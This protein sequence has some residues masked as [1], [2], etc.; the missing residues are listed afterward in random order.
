[1]KAIMKTKRQPGVEF[2][3]V[4]SPRVGPHDVLIRVHVAGICGTDFHIYMWDEWSAGRVGPPIVL[5]H[6][7]IGDVVDVGAEVTTVEVGDCV[8]AEGH[9]SCGQCFQ[10][11]TG[12]QHICERV[13][14]IGIDRDGCFAE[15]LSVPERNVWKMDR[16]IPSDVAAITDPIGNA[17]HTV[18]SG[19]IS[20]CTAAI[21]GC[22]STGLAAIAVAKACGAT[23]VFAL[24]VSE[25]KLALS[26][27]MGA[28]TAIND[29]T[30]DAAETVLE[31]TAGV[32]V[33]V[34]AEMSGSPVGF[35]TALKIARR[36]G[37]ISVLGLP[38]S[39]V[40][41]DLANDVVLR[42]VTINGVHGR[43]M[44]GTWYQ[45]TRLLS[46]GRLDVS[47][48][49]THR[50]PFAEFDAAMDV[51]KSGQCGKILLMPPKE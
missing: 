23:E 5:G 41:L 13:Q 6:E 29:A 33:D 18:L 28:D 39:T 40:T 50:M 24:D 36:G 22:G 37:R 3:D 51:L 43:R 42:G 31:K 30:E 20:G 10:C 44:F 15:Y 38:K 7:F 14:V 19:E 49:I 17:V 45:T 35:Q 21:V 48:I 9:I 47:P 2:K 8:T 26:R 12:S 16:S 4:G 1:M 32:G 25:Y 34:V 11:R 46:S 27:T